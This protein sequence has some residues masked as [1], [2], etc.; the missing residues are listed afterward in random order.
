MRG[1]VVPAKPFNQL[2]PS[3]SAKADDPVF[4]SIAILRG[5]LEY[6]MPACAGMTP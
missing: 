3:S 5:A 2:P 4:Q 6:W 1:L